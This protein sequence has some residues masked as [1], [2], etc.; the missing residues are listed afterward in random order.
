M[1]AS[2]PAISRLQRSF[3]GNACSVIINCATG[4]LR[5]TLLR[6]RP[7]ICKIGMQLLS[8]WPNE[9]C[10][11]SSHGGPIALH[12]SDERKLETCV[13]RW[14]PGPLGNLSFVYTCCPLNYPRLWMMGWVLNY[15]RVAPRRV[16]PA[17]RLDANC[18]GQGRLLEDED[19]GR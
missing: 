4:L 18:A 7:E 2:D 15:I 11:V 19:Y 3:S 5:V 10:F 14:P 16:L 17:P 13:A 12:T 1:R 6:H 8:P 9:I